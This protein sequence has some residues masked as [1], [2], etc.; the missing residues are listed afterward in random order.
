MTAK[1]KKR[2]RKSYTDE[3][4]SQI[5]ATAKKEGLTALAVEKRFGVKPITYYSWRKKAGTTRSS[6]GAASRKVS[7]A[8]LDANLRSSV[9]VKLQNLLPAIVDQEVNRYL[10]A[11]FGAKRRGGPR[12]RS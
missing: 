3:Q 11:A 9:Q 4:R 12:G 10:D 1:K 2:S 7:T 6:R 5:M 8:G